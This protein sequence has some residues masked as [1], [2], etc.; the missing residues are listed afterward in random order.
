VNNR[1][2]NAKGDFNPGDGN[3]DGNGDRR[4]FDFSMR[5][6]NYRT[7]I[8]IYG[9]GSAVQPRMERR[10]NFRRRHE[11]PHGQRQ[12]TRRQIKTLA[13]PAADLAVSALQSIYKLAGNVPSAS[14]F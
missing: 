10:A 5:N 6:A 14:G 2:F 12:N 4:S 11:Q 8:V 3:S 13:Q 9:N 7:I 1:K